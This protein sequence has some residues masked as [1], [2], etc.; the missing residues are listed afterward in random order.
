VCLVTLLAVMVGAA[1]RAER[2]CA[3]RR[4]ILHRGLRLS[5]FFSDKLLS[6]SRAR[7]TRTTDTMLRAAAQ[8]ARKVRW[9]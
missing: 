7:L 1:E 4:A 8:S 3:E 6:G 2:K 9:L 5:Y